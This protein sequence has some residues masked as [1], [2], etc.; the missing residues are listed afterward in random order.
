MGKATSRVYSRVNSGVVG[1]GKSYYADDCILFYKL[2]K[3]P[4]NEV[5]II[6]L[7]ALYNIVIFT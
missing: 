1:H 6:T 4:K 3:L 2:Y 7:N 5:S